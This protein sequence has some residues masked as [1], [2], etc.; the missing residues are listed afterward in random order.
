MTGPSRH[1]IGSIIAH[2]EACLLQHGDTPRGMDWP[3]AEDLD[4]RFAVM[5]GVVLD[6]VRQNQIL[7]LGCGTGLFLE[8][9][10]RHS[11][12]PPW[13]Y[14]GI[15]ISGRMI[16][17]A[18]RNRPVDSF[19]RRD[20]LESPLPSQSVD[21]VI[22]NGLLT[23][24]QSMS[25]AAMIA[26]AGDIIR[27][28]FASARIGI[29]FNVMSKHVDWERDDLFHWGLDE[30]ATFL[31]E[32]ISRHFVVRNDYGLYEY[33]IYAYRDAPPPSRSLRPDR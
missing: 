33:T 2:Y 9:L 15:D 5:A 6:H 14:C 3:N 20:I 23:E 21:Y 25:Q 4:R 10:R 13:Q 11:L 19:E 28:A 16:A 8:Y 7:D 18:R 30:L 1:D 29:A 17:M 27:A 26:F 22:M 32:N 31:T 24:K 12:A